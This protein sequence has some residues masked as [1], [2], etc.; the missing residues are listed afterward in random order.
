MYRVKLVSVSI[1]G[2]T[3]AIHDSITQVPGSFK[4][5]L[6]GIDLLK[7]YGIPFE[8]KCVVLAENVAHIEQIRQL[9]MRLNKGR[10]CKIDFSLCGK[11]NGDCNNFSHQ[12]SFQAIKQVFFSNPERYF[13]VNNLVARQPSDSPCGAGKYGLYCS[14][15][16]YIYPCVS[17]RLLLCNY[18]ELQGIHQNAVLKKWLSTK[19]SDFSNCFQHDYCNFCTEQ[20]AGNNLIENGNYLNSTNISNCERAKIIAEWFDLYSNNIKKD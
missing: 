3:E 15:E 19:L 5:T 12:A 14:A 20:C 17:F 9:S 18:K 11:I 8:L 13:D 10:D 7:K 4:K 16:G 1:Y 2:D 6:A